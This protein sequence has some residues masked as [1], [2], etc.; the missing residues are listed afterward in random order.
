MA[1]L[2][3]VK[4]SSICYN[5]IQVNANVRFDIMGH[6]LSTI[7]SFHYQLVISKYKMAFAV[8]KELIGKYMKNNKFVFI[9]TRQT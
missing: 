5:Y 6:V 4:D 8:I 9:S 7:L 1:R 3:R 2:E